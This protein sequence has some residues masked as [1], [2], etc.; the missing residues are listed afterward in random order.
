MM[1]LKPRILS[2]AVAAL[3]LAAAA[4]PATAEPHD[5]LRVFTTVPDLAA[6]AKRVGGTHVAVFSMVE[7]RE[8]AHFAEPK[9]SFVKKLA[10]VR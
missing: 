4:S 7:G 2:A 9:P 8:D 1:T 6:L 10:V 3:A 5:P